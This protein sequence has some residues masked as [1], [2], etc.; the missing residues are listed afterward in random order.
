M[1]LKMKKLILHDYQTVAELIK[2]F[3][4]K[5][6]VKRMGNDFVGVYYEVE[7]IKKLKSNADT[8]WR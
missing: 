2:A 8:K 4:G 3:G 6:K 1:P 7:I 5:V